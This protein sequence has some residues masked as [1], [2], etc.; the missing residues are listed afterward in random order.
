MTRCVKVIKGLSKGSGIRHPYFT[1]AGAGEG[2][3]KRK[4]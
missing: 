2:R 4:N 3:I 1:Q